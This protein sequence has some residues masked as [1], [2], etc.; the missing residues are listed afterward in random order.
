MKVLNLIAKTR[1][2]RRYKECNKI[3]MSKLEYLAQAARFVGSAKNAQRLRLLLINDERCDAVFENIRFAAN[4]DWNGPEIGQRPPA[5][6]IV[7][8]E[9]EPDTNLAID[10]GLAAE[11][12]LIT[13]TEEGLGG[14]MFRSFDREKL[15]KVLGKAPYMPALVIAIGEPDEVVI[16]QDVNPNRENP[17]MYF[18]DDYGHHLVPKIGLQTIVLK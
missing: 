7:M 5:Y 2:Y 18:R 1:S 9:E 4:L 12:M 10:I 17:L 11:A 6:I 3:P 16:L 15:G 13:A 8:T 14:C